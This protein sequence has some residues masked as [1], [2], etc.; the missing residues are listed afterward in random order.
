MSVAKSTISDSTF[1]SEHDEQAGF[2]AWFRAQF[3]GV[4]I[5]AVP[6]GGR[7]AISEAK[8]LRDEGV[9]PGVPDLCVPAWGLWIEM[10]RARGGRLSSEQRGVIAYLERIGH[11]VI[12]GCGARDASAQVIE[13]VKARFCG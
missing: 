4:L 12:V 2:V 10:K 9:V 7:R 8:R 3:P 11:T 6:N 13:F 1:R 5:F